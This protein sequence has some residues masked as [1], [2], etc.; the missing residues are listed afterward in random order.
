MMVKKVNKNLKESRFT[1]KLFYKN[2][3]FYVAKI[4]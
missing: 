3:F 2:M 4:K 1:V